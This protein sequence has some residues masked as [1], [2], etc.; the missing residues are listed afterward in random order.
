M[1]RGLMSK[2]RRA[3]QYG[4]AM[5]TRKTINDEFVT[6]LGFANAGMLNP[7][8]VYLLDLAVR[9]APANGAFVEIG[10]F[11]GLSTNCIQ[12]FKRKHGRDNPFFS[13]DRWIFEN[14]ENATLGTG[15][16]THAE[17]RAFVMDTF[18]RNVRFFGAGMLPHTIEMFSDEFFDAWRAG[19]AAIDVFGRPVTLGGPVSFAY[20]DGNH[21]YEYAKRDWQNV[22]EFLLPGGLVLFDDSAPHLEFEVYPV[23]QELRRNPRYELVAANPNHLFRKLS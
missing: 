13:C 8:N 3:V 11:C 22:D 2:V 18:R 1:A 14:S 12:H 9:E 17:Y 16:I 15:P 4:H 10:S 19:A 21:T 20:V 7:G 5:V 6:W 23:T